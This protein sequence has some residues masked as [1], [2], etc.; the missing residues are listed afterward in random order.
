MFWKNN[1]FSVFAKKLVGK[2]VK[3]FPCRVKWTMF[4]GLLG[5]GRACNLLWG[6]WSTSS[7]EGWESNLS[8]RAVKALWEANKARNIGNSGVHSGRESSELLAIKQK[9][10]YFLW[11]CFMKIKNQ[12]FRCINSYAY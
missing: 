11:Y 9:K 8:G 6:K 12:T 5:G 7:L 3:A 4:R 1:Y 10:N 2:A